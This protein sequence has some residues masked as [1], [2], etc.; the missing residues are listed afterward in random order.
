VNDS[1]YHE[2]LVRRILSGKQVFVCNDITYELRKPPLSLRIKADIL[3]TDAY[4]SNLYN[5]F[6]FLED[7]E[8]LLFELQI[9]PYD[10]KK[11]MS[12]IEKS[13]ESSKISLYQQYFDTTKRNKTRQRIQNLKKDLDQFLQ[14]EHSLDYI[15]LEHYCDNIRNEFLITN[16]LYEYNTD[17]LIFNHSNINYNSF[18][19]LASKISQNLIDVSTFKAIARSEYWRNYWNNNKSNILDDCVK[20]WSEEQKS[21]I[22]ISYMYDKI[23]E[24]PECPQQ[25]II[26]D[27]DALDGWMLFNKKENER[28]KKQ[29][30][31]ENILSGNLKNASEVF[32][33]AN[34]REQADDILGLNNSAGLATLKQ[35]VDFVTN[36]KINDGERIPDSQLPD[37]KQRIMQQLNSKG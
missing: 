31:V 37:V 13:L 24:H 4:E 22:N 6:W 10:Y 14:K 11:I 33:M 27:D 16:T 2:I 8:N 28:Q 12:Q 29:K 1:K 17:N 7:I 35:K 19:S 20:E 21:L 23:Y 25:D 9:L 36:T 15:T 18:N 30:G 26:N 3:Y 34:S 32:L 5:D